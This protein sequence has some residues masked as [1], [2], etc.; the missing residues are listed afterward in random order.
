M[1]TSKKSVELPDKPSKA[2]YQNIPRSSKTIL[3]HQKNLGKMRR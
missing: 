2:E 1:V 3:N